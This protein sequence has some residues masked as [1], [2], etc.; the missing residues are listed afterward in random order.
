MES[1]PSTNTYAWDLID[2]GK[3]SG[4]ILT[5]NQYNG[6]GKRNNNW[7]S[8]IHG[9]IA[10]SLF[11]NR[12]LPSNQLGVLPVLAGLSIQEALLNHAVTV[13]LK[14]PNDILLK[15]KKIGGILC[16][17]NTRGKVSKYIIIGIGMNVN[18]NQKSLNKN[19]L[20]NATSLKIVHNKEYGREKIISSIIDQLMLNLNSFP[21]NSK[22]IIKRW[23]L[24]CSHMNEEV[25]F[26]NNSLSVSGVFKGLNSDGSA[27][28]SVNNK[29]KKLTK[30]KFL[31]F[32][33]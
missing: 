18:D 2:K 22:D 16:E 8:S 32:Y 19:N 31:N 6:K 3:E 10:F 12:E 1:L 27:K 15:N 13:S 23:E 29:L 9:G 11:L 5:S 25:A 33:R 7:L 24:N 26:K 28:I 17:S 30:I 4:I 14:W 21:M 20:H